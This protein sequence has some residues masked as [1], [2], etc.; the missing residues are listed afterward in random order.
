MIGLC[1]LEEENAQ[2]IPMIPVL[3]WF[4]QLGGIMELEDH[5]LWLVPKS[6][7]QIIKNWKVSWAKIHDTLNP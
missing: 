5:G 7:K 3:T 1:Q 4:T 6:M 2:N